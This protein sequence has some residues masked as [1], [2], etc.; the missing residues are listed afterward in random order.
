MASY[1]VY[2]VFNPCFVFFISKT[3]YSKY[4]YTIN[5][6]KNNSLNFVH[7]SYGPLITVIK[8]LTSGGIPQ[9]TIK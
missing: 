7:T 8:S 5:T 9:Y 3:I 2:N 4:N 6:I 1:K